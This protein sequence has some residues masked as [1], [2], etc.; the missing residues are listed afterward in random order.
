MPEH[1][2]WALIG[3]SDI[4]ATRLLPAIRAVGDT[5]VVVRSGDAGHAAAWARLH[6]VEDSVTDL[7]AALERDD[8]D[9]VYVSSVNA[10]HREHVE[11]A[12][13]AGKHVLAEKPLA[14]SLADAVAMVETCRA[15][16]VVMATNHHLPA[17]PTHRTLKRAV[18]DGLVGDVRA[19]RV[20]YAV[21]LP[22]RLAGWRIDDPVGGGVVLDISIHD[23]A[24][25]AAILGTRPLEV[26]AVGQNQDNSPDGPFDAVLTDAV[27]EGGV[28]VQ[29]HDAYNNAHLPTSLHVLGTEGAL[30]ADDC[31]SQLPVGGV[32]LWRDNVAEPLDVGTRDDLYQVTVRAFGDAVRGEGQ[33]LISGEDGVRSL[34]FSLAVLESLRT[35]S[36][37]AVSTTFTR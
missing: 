6:G 22:A 17:S 34:A 11:A 9:A 32:A 35:S 5:A 33:V 21:Q 16:G 26:T 14:L 18:A 3:A 31:N 36:R 24:A 7:Q 30:V 1:L 8:V 15:A 13:A 27:W 19:V 37:T 20:H 29:T 12:A 23:A 28:L 25:V 2:R 4:A 10:S